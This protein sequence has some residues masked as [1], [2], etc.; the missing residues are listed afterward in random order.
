M[1]TAVTSNIIPKILCNVTDVVNVT[2]NQGWKTFQLY[3]TSKVE[4][5][6]QLSSPF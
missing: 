5:N 6:V 1:C 2:V 4:P 3:Y